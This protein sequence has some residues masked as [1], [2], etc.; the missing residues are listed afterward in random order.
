MPDPAKVEEVLDMLSGPREVFRRDITDIDKLMA[1]VCD[2]AESLAKKRR[3]PAWA[4]IGDITQ[5]GSWVSSAIYE[6]YRR[7]DEKGDGE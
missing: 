5:H 4:I 2:Y 6:L 3:V 1:A 7:R